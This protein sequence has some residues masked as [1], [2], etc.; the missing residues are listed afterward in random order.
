VKK[1]AKQ[2]K[3]SQMLSIVVSWR[4][5]DELD[6]SLPPLIRSCEALGGEVILVNYDGDEQHLGRQLRGLDS[7]SLR[8]VRVTGEKYF[9]KSRAQ[10]IG[11]HRSQHPIL[12]FCD[13]DIIVTPAE[14]VEL[15]R[16]LFERPGIFATLAGVTESEQ[17]SRQAGNVV[18]FGYELNLRLA[19]GRRLKIVDNEEDVENGTRQAPGL[20]LVR[21]EDFVRIDGY[22]SRL[23]GWGWED[24]DMISRLTLGLGLT[25]VLRGTA[26]HL[27]HSDEARIAN[28]P[29]VKDRWESRD[30]MFRQALANYDA[31]DFQG[32][33]TKDNLEGPAKSS[34]IGT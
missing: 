14:I 5:R 15:S 4:N 24:Q 19:N 21:H 34:I 16:D 7:N 26:I 10:N 6:Q 32:T 20:L 9:N 3:D 25:R 12:F 31:A 13:C 33:Y 11:A 2:S 27:S 22:N 29:P 8:V 30:R 28:Y 23:H 1:P 18:C 17:N